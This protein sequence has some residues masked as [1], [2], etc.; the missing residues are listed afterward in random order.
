MNS[1]WSS[2]L[3]RYSSLEF[4]SRALCT[5]PHMQYTSF[6]VQYC[7]LSC[8]ILYTLHVHV[9][10]AS[11]HAFPHEIHVK[12]KLER[13]SKGCEYNT[14]SCY[15]RTINITSTDIHSNSHMPHL[16]PVWE[17]GQNLD[18]AVPIRDHNYHHACL[19]LAP[20][21]SPPHASGKVTWCVCVCVCVVLLDTES[22]CQRW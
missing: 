2:G 15:R 14:V 13:Y 6:N 8:F 11:F 20:S 22:E 17:V 1:G 10:L 19:Q 16:P 7:T 21:G 4:K 3:L 12:A 5:I 18:M 9:P